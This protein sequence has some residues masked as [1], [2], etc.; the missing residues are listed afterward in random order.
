MDSSFRLGIAALIASVL[1]VGARPVTIPTVKQWSEAPGTYSIT[2]ASRIVIPAPAPASLE[3]TARVLARDLRALT[4]STLPILSGSDQDGDIVLRIATVELA[5]KEEGYRMEIGSRLEITGG[6]EDGVFNGTRTLLQLLKNNRAVPRGSVVDWPDYPE[7]GLMVDVGRKYFTVRWIKD[8][9]LDLAYAKMNLLHL[10]LS[11]DLGIRV[12]SEK[13]PDIVSRP[14]YSKNEIREIVALAQEYHV[15]II[16]EVD[17]PAHT[18]WLR[19]SHPELLLG[20]NGL[21]THYMDI[22]KPAALDLVEDILGEYLPEF[23]GPYW[24]MGADEY[25]GAADYP[26]YPSL[27]AYAKARYGPAANGIDAYLAFIGWVHGLV[28]AQGKVLRTWAD[29]YEYNAINP[30]SPVPLDRSIVQEAWNAHENPKEI[31]AAGFFIQN[32]SFHPTYYNLGAYKG[33]EAV[34][35]E[36]WAPHKRLGG[37]E[38]PGW[39]YPM[40]IDSLHPKLLGA[41]LSV[42]CDSPESETESEVAEGIHGRLRAIAQN[43]WG[44]PKAVSDYAEFRKVITAIGRAPGYGEDTPLGIGPARPLSSA[45]TPSTLDADGP[46]FDAKGRWRPGNLNRPGPPL[47]RPQALDPGSLFPS[48][49]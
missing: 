11:D 20:S 6:G 41:K 4:G 45:G 38:R 32:A 8:H 9:I 35:Y 23:P 31:A 14:F 3:R 24:H 47:Y 36:D 19:N 28:K 39:I 15:T 49:R 37:W 1:P 48:N 34:L 43:S 26:K 44:G 13:H 30:S 2:P 18:G 22:T 16:P 27:D 21:G 29:A 33:E 40:A 46:S 25:I 17:V 7:R 5:G 12:A 42:W 10:H